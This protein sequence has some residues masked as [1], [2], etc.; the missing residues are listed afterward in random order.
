MVTVRFDVVLVAIYPTVG[1]KIRKSRPC[2][3]I[4]PDQINRHMQTVIVAPMTTRGR[5][6]PFRVPCRFQSK[7]GHIA[8]DQIRAIDRSRVA[9]RLG[10]VGA[11]AQL[12]H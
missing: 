6:Y 11:K 3:V 12:R 1:S 4:S 10:T 2:L 7:D 9:R 8:L 5:R